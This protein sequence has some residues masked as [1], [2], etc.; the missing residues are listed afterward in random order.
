M[1]K[2]VVGHVI[3]GIAKNATTVSSRSRVPVPAD[4]SVCKLP[5]R[6]SQ[7]NEQRGW[8]DQPVLIHW[9]V[10][11]DAMKDEME[12]NPNPVIR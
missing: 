8:H 10:V 2:E 6:C 7:N 1:V 9:Q 11:V 5:E 12:S 4:D 3:A